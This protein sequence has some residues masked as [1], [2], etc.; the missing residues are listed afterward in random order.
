MNESKHFGLVGGLGVG[1]TVIYYQAIAAA[2]AERDIVP[3][4]TMAHANA[5]TALACVQAGRIDGS[6][7][8]SRASC[9]SSPRQGPTS[10]P[11]PP[12]RRTSAWPT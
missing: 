3:R 5:P 11:F 4:L 12:S 8:T 7:P 9:G 1:A 6:P 2:C 10:S